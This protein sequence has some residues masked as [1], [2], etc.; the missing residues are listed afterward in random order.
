MSDCTFTNGGKTKES[1]ASG[2][3]RQVP[4]K[5]KA[6]GLIKKFTV[7]IILWIQS[8]V[9]DLKVQTKTVGGILMLEKKTFKSNLVILFI[10][11]IFLLWMI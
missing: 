9:C 5:N 6:S 3:K 10:T 2:Q 4:I 1:V 11:M 8:L 7:M